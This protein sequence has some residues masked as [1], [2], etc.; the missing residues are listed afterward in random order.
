MKSKFLIFTLV[1]LFAIGCSDPCDDPV[2]LEC[3]TGDA[4]MD[5]VI[6]SDDVAPSDPCLPED[7][8]ACLTGDLDN[9]G[10]TNGEDSDPLERCLPKVPDLELN[11]IGNWSWGFGF[12]MIEFL[13]D[14]T[15]K[16]GENQLLTFGDGIEIAS[17]TWSVNSNNNLV[18]S[19]TNN[20]GASVPTEA[21]IISNECD[22]VTLMW[23][24]TELTFTR[25]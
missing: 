17:K 23:F 21:E 11:I 19:I 3:E 22:L 14:G 7:N 2:N 20:N 10:L 8:L 1:T 16:E 24:T 25:L 5:G 15:Y 18:L 9:D 13:E 12:G 6:N 4:D